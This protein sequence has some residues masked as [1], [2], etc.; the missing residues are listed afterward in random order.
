MK[1]G[2]GLLLCS[3]MLPAVAD[4][5][6]YFNSIRQDPNALYAF[7]K[8]MPKSGELHYHLDGGAYPEVMLSL[9]AKQPYCLDPKTAVI[10][11]TNKQCDG[12]NT[13]DL[14]HQPHLYS[15]VIN[16]WSM[17][18]FVPG[19]ESGHDHFF[20]SFSKFLPIVF[21]FRA[22]LLADAMKRAS[23]QHELYLEVMVAP[24]NA[25]SAFFANT[26]QVKK[27]F[28]SKK[29]TLLAN[30]SFQHTIKN[31]GVKATTILQ[32]ARQDL[33]CTKAPHQPVCSLT[34]TFQYYVL[35]EQSL[36]QFFAQALHGFAVVAAHPHEFVGINLVQAEDGLISLRDYRQQM[37]IF[38]FLHKAYPTVHIALHAGELSAK[39]VVPSA[40]RFHIHD[41]IFTGQ[42]ERIGH[43]A[44]IAYEDNAESL[45]KYM[46]KIPIPVEINL[47]SNQKIL[48]LS[49]KAHPL[50]YYLAHHIPIVL[51]TD[52]EGVLRTDL[53]QEYVAAVMK[54]G[55]NYSTLKTINRNGLTYSF[56]PGKSLW[57]NP[58]TATPI[59]ACEQFDS[60]SC[61]LFIQ[62][63]SKANLQWQL[64]KSLKDFEQQFRL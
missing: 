28:S 35:R 51:S 10:S 41:A 52:D 2:L 56:L 23:N 21:D 26:I 48:G 15:Q 64:E 16:A 31:T 25:A 49:G 19:Q 9:A 40:L 61:L 22:E 24:D 4:V 62:K 37:Q 6:E 7:Y 3:I 18:H 55:L 8:N 29:Q 50:N 38:K 42:A 58:M 17:R 27:D 30:E 60:R 44:S 54:Q 5:Q 57:Q 46:A 53:T 13:S 59:Q 36:D 33:G 34:V 20:A 1:Y 39:D 47:T 63:N 32:K 14:I 12:I 45:L 43:G 11:K